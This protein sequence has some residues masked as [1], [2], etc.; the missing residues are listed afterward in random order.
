MLMVSPP[1]PESI[2]VCEKTFP[3]GLPSSFEAPKAYTN[4]QKQANETEKNSEPGS[5]K[6]QK[7]AL[8]C[9]R[10]RNS[11]PHQGQAKMVA[12]HEQTWRW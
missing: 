2:S 3:V 7:L 11:S 8:V 12:I 5:S 4:C 9:P 6:S 10:R 1:T